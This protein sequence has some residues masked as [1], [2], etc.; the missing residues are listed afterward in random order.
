MKQRIPTQRVSGTPLNNR[1]TTINYVAAARKEFKECLEEQFYKI[2]RL[3]YER[4]TSDISQ[5]T[6]AGLECRKHYFQTMKGATNI[7]EE[8]IEKLMRTEFE[9]QIRFYAKLE[10]IR[11]HFQ[12]LSGSWVRFGIQFPDRLDRGYD[13]QTGLTVGCNI[14]VGSTGFFAFPLVDA[15]TA[16][17]GK[18]R[19]RVLYV[20]KDCVITLASVPAAVEP[21]QSPE[22]WAEE[23]AQQG[24]DSVKD[25]SRDFPQTR[26]AVAYGNF[27]LLDSE[28]TFSHKELA[29]LREKHGV[30]AIVKADSTNR[31]A[32]IYTGQEDIPLHIQ[33]ELLH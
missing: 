1:N 16:T 32:L 6:K 25:V 8:A 13:W 4:R 7:T 21:F 14:S 26:T 20:D 24:R 22:V 19:C 23:F 11:E 2:A 5:I 12:H 31:Q 29:A 15:R 10:K 18:E 33:L 9:R 3:T 27:L 30:H 17:Y 28:E